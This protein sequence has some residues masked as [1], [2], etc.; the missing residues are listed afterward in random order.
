MSKE[1]MQDGQKQY[2]E[3][4]GWDAIQV[5]CA[6]EQALGQVII[7]A[8]IGIRER[9]I[10]R[11]VNRRIK[12]AGENVIWNAQPQSTGE[13]VKSQRDKNIKNAR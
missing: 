4:A 2:I 7:K 12:A 6:D 5:F 8:C 9:N 10:G 1:I 13:N 11:R 3:R